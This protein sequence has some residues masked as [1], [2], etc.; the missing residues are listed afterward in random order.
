MDSPKILT[1]SGAA[2]RLGVGLQQ[3]YTL[4]W[5][6]QLLG[7]KIDGRWVI[8]LASVEARQSAL[9]ARNGVVRES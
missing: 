1:V 3:V 4:L 5:A 8:S 2:R 6:G 7:Q 9:Q